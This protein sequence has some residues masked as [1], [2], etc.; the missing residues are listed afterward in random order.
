M[1]NATTGTL[2]FAR[3]IEEAEALLLGEQAKSCTKC[4]NCDSE[5]C[6]SNKTERA[7]RKPMV[8]ATAR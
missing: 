1:N 6:S 2:N 7:I 5:K 8:S 3:L 4:G